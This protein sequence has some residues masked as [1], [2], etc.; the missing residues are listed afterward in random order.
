[1]FAAVYGVLL[2]FFGSLAHLQE[3][4][5]ESLKENLEISLKVYEKIG[6]SGENMEI[7]RD[8]VP[9][10]MDVSIQ[11]MPA[12]AFV[13]FLLVIL[14]NLFLLYRRFPDRHS[15]FVSAGDLKEWRS[16]EPLIWCFILSGFCLF[17]PGWQMLKAWALN[18]FIVI[19]VF[20]F[21]QGLAIVAYYFHHK[22][23]PFFFRS[24]AYVLIIFEQIF[25][26]LVVGL[27][28]FD[29]WGDFRRLKKKDLNP[30]RVS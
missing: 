7:L 8:R 5:R 26:L 24:L 15:F 19:A 23:V 11:I 29:L 27:G 9:Q 1:M 14:I 22:R 16:P 3:M 6:L 12:L 18:L 25:T 20:Y 17:L 13:S 10:V 2:Y 28:L 4:L 21:F 30:S